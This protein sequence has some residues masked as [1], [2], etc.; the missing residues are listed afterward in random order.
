ML[1]HI[2][3]PDLYDFQIIDMFPSR[4][5]LRKIVDMFLEPNFRTGVET[6][7]QNHFLVQR[8]DYSFDVKKA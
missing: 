5:K 4:D 1:I 6:V 8:R 7:Y 3:S 2:K